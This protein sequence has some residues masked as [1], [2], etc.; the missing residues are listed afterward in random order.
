MTTCARLLHHSPLL[1]P[2]VMVHFIPFLIFLSYHR[3]SPSHRSFLSSLV[4]EHEP[5]SYSEAKNFP[6][7]RNAIQSEIDTLR[8]NR[9]QSLVPLLDRKKP[10][11]CR[12]VYKIKRHSN[13]SIELYK[14]WLI[15]KGY[16]QIEGVDYFDTFAPIAKLVIVRVPLFVA[17]TKA[18]PLYQLDINNA[19]LHRDLHEDVYMQLP[20]CFRHQGDNLICKLQKSLYGL[21]QASPN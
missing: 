17:T 15:A 6:E 20:P 10:I 7:W 21:K 8:E 19:F 2:M 11:G 18:W 13:G 12:W 1:L 16:T 4:V 14:A 9:T 3:F 5:K